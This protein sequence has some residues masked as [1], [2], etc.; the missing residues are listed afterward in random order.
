V[1]YFY[2]KAINSRG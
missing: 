1:R 2:I